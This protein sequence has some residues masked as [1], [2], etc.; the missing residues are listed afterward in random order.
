MEA[1]ADLAAAASPPTGQQT[2]VVR[3]QYICAGQSV[4]IVVRVPE[5][6]TDLVVA[7]LGKLTTAA[8]VAGGVSVPVIQVIGHRGNNCQVLLL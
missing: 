3:Q 6:Q 7:L 2:T 8:E 1:L 4:E 5:P